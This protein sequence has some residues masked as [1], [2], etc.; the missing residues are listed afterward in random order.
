MKSIKLFLLWL[1]DCLRTAVAI[2]LKR[3]ALKRILKNG[4]FKSFPIY[5]ISFNRLSL[6]K[7][8]VEWLKKNGYSN[9][10]IVDNCSTYKPLVEYLSSCDCKVIR[11]KGNY[12]HEV[13]YRHPR[14][15]FIRNFTFF[16]LTDPDLMPVSECP[17]DFIEVFVKAMFKYPKFPKVGFS[18]KLDDIP[19]EYYLKAEVLKW[20]T[21]FYDNKI[22]C[23]KVV[24]YD[25]RID[26][27]FAVNAPLLFKSRRKKYSGIRTGFPYQVRHLPWYGEKKSDELEYYLK[28]VRK[29]VSNWNGN[30]SKERMQKRIKKHM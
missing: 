22:E 11:M 6:V 10:N 23:N 20:E 27:T 16:A 26:T 21:R 1:E 2:P 19:D 5:I 12:G 15:F 28:S 29:D 9:I 13:V 30:I 3:I 8:T 25:S 4:N 17:S 24:L 18:L 14:F 7:Q